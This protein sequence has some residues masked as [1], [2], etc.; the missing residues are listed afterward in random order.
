VLWTVGS[1]LDFRECV[2][3]EGVRWTVGSALD[4][5]ECVGLYK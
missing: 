2:G 4:C 1:A 5:R 3:L